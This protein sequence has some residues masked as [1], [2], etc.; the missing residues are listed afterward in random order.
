MLGFQHRSQKLILAL[1]MIVQRSFGD[2][3][4]RRNLVHAHAAI[5]PLAEEPVSGIKD[6]FLR[7]F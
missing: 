1:K 6:A 3:R 2:P 4:G 5:A 7:A